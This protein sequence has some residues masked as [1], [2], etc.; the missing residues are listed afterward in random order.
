MRKLKTATEKNENK[1]YIKTAVNDTMK[2]A[3]EMTYTYWN[4]L[5]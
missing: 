1:G 4:R 2:V 3:K 5:S